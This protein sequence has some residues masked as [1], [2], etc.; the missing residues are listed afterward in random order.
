M[1][2]SDRR[3]AEGSAKS[4]HPLIL[5]INKNP[6]RYRQQAG[7][8]Q[9]GQVP[10]EKHQLNRLLIDSDSFNFDFSV[11]PGLVLWR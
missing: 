2:I 7:D 8:Y 9:V 4:A 11:W 3:E 10:P 5:R 1:I 6:H